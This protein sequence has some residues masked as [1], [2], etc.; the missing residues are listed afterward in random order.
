M[1]ARILLTLS[2]V[3]FPLSITAENA[4]PKKAM[5]PVCAVRGETEEEKVKAHREKDGKAYYFCSKGCAK[6]FD[7]DPTAFVPPELPRPAPGIVVETLDGEAVDL[8]AFKGKVV[9]LDFWASWCKPCVE[10]MPSLQKIHDAYADRGVTV[11]GVSIDEGKD[12]VKK[13]RKF[14]EKVGV[15][16]PIYSDARPT[17]AWHTFKV[18]AI[19]ALF[20]IDREGRIV[21]QWLGTVDHGALEAEIK[22]NL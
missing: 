19:P 5:C 11:V 20:L 6:E 21:A 17:P 10:M 9:V 2:L 16:Y 22:K 14:V 15:T 7:A 4:R 13:I 18:K 3:A 8:S 12:R 1:Y